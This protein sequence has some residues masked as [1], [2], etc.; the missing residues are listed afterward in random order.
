MNLKILTHILYVL[1]LLWIVSMI[2]LESFTRAE[3][4][5]IKRQN[6]RIENSVSKINDYI[7]K[8]EEEWIKVYT[9]IEE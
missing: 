9:V 8:L 7:E 6:D 2:L 3:L 4:A 1:L 5:S